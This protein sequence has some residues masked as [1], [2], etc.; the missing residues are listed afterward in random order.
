[1][2]GNAIRQAKRYNDTRT[3]C[4]RPAAGFTYIELV[5]ILLILGILTMIGVPALN[6]SMR[7][8]AL[9]GAT[10]EVVNAL[11]YAQLRATTGRRTR[12]MI[13]DSENRILVTQFRP[14]ADLFTGG[15]TLNSNTVEGGTFQPMANPLNK[16]TD[17]DLYFANSDQFQKVNI[18]SS[19]FNTSDPVIFDFSGSPSKGGSVTL[20]LGGSQLVVSV[21]AMSGKVTVSP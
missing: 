6:S 13:S 19:D 12:V 16:G 2:K 18:I 1:M 11:E 15:D 7:D 20:G 9:T 4:R 5:M 10:Q 17:Y 3:I 14:I 8:S 21:N